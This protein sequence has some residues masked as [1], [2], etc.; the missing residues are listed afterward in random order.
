MGRVRLPQ[1][2]M[3]DLGNAPPPSGVEEARSVPILLARGLSIFA[4]AGLIGLAAVAV[5]AQQ[6]SLGA[7]R[8]ANREA[9]YWSAAQLEQDYAGFLEALAS[10]GAG[11]P[12]ADIAAVER[13]FDRL[14]SRVVLFERGTVGA[15]FA[16]Y[17]ED[18]RAIGRVIA[19]L[20]R[21]EHS[22]LRLRR[23]EPGAVVSL[24]A[25]FRPLR[26]DLAALS[27]RVFNGEERRR[28]LVRA[29]IRRTGQLAW[30]VSAA[31]MGLASILFGVMLVET[32]HY[33]RV[34]EA[35]K[36][37]AW[38]A[39][40]ANQVK[41][42]FLTMMSHEL[43]TPLNGVLGI[44][45]L[46][47][48]TRL[49]DSQTRLV[50]HAQRSGAEMV[51]LLGDL[52][53]FSDLQTGTLELKS[54]PFTLDML[55][56]GI[57]DNLASVLTRE[58]AQLSLRLEPASGALAIGD[59]PRIAQAVGSFVTFLVARVGAREIS[60][61]IAHRTGWLLIDMECALPPGP[62]TGW[63][64]EAIFGHDRGA[65]E[66]FGS[67]S[68]GPMIGR[69]LVRLMAGWVRLVRTGPDAMRLEMALPAEAEASSASLARIEVGSRTLAAL[70][71][72]H[73]TGLGWRLWHHGQDPGGVGLVLVEAAETA[74]PTTQSKRLAG[75][76]A[77]HPRAAVLAL[78]PQ[79]DALEADA[80][81]ELPI[82]RIGLSAALK[83]LRVS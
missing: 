15:R 81:C 60:L 14:W 69:A 51:T 74:E 67:D 82:D 65:A 52:Q 58:G 66:V 1:S 71:G 8:E 40:R 17:G 4:L 32:R 59:A 38:R 35:N 36:R 16:A 83:R 77:E 76:R 34:A 29:R 28:A 50:D 62:G 23:E 6:S 57:E 11:D 24:L 48:Q 19:L 64:P 39:E 25:V 3:L 45:A 53:D 56:R 43:R 79:A 30:A 73:L 9:L 18:G 13:Q 37:S 44:L 5:W 33:R 47:R 68:L 70:A 41:S 10:F 31:A 46:M 72:A 20:R 55:A 61:R 54:D 2:G 21:H 80:F 78:G 42:R 27:T 49:T 75:L 22:L 26:R 7:L 63:E 12:A